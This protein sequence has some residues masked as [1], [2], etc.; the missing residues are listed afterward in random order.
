MMINWWEIR[1]PSVGIEETL[2][3]FLN[4]LTEFMPQNIHFGDVSYTIELQIPSL[5][6]I[7]ENTMRII[8]RIAIDSG[9]QVVDISYVDNILHMRVQ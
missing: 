3:V 8:K 5:M 2:K 6:N 9:L 1:N 7:D 4:K